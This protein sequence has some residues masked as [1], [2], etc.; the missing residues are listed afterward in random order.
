MRY[1]ILAPDSARI[2]R[3]NGFLGDLREKSCYFCQICAILKPQSEHGFI[4]PKGFLGYGLKAEQKNVHAK[5]R[6]QSKDTKD[7]RLKLTN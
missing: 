1:I 3:N 6:T 4:D 2:K 7:F 5:T